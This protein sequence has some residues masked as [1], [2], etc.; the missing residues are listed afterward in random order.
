MIWGASEPCNWWTGM[1]YLG[2]RR[3]TKLWPAKHIAHIEALMRCIK[4]VTKKSAA[5]LWHKK[6]QKCSNL[7]TKLSLV[8]VNLFGSF[9]EG[10]RRIFRERESGL[11]FWASHDRRSPNPCGSS[12]LVQILNFLGNL[13]ERE[14]QRYES[15]EDLACGFLCD[16]ECLSVNVG[17]VLKYYCWIKSDD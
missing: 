17:I 13:R 11:Y 12:T 7:C 8:V 3:T 2:Q 15:L 6:S 16:S 1:A 14:F 4:G 9:R 10:C 5:N